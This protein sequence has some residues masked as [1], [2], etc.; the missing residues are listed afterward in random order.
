MKRGSDT[1]GG[2]EAWHE[3]RSNPEYR[4]D[5]QA[6]GTAEHAL[7]PASFP[8][9]VQSEADLEAARWGLL[10]WED[11]RVRNRGLPFR[12]GVSMLTG[13]A[14][15]AAVRGGPSLAR[16]VRES[17]AI[18]TGLRLRDGTVILKVER[19]GKV[20]QVRLCDWDAF[21]PERDS[22]QLGVPLD[23]IPPTSWARAEELTAMMALPA[24]RS[25]AGRSAGRRS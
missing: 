4:A 18:F 5:W 19:R 2:R 14:A 24:R 25:G 23:A 22:L 13:H 3:L 6:Y 15:P 17:P 1:A 12:A 16:L 9:R 21:D 20:E 7:E 8:L 10:A 11:P